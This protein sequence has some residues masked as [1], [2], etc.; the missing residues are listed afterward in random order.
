VADTKVTWRIT[1][2]EVNNAGEIDVN[3]KFACRNPG[4]RNKVTDPRDPQGSME[5]VPY[6]HKFS[7][8]ATH[9]ATG[10]ESSAFQITVV[11]WG[12]PL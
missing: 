11:G 10:V 8:V 12:G 5:W 4:G 6:E 1:K 2:N 7:V 3:G 9:S